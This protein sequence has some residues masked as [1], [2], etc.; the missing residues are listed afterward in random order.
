MRIKMFSCS[1]CNDETKIKFL[2]LEEEINA[3]L[4]DHPDIEIIDRKQSLSCSVSEHVDISYY[5]ECL[6][7]IFY[8]YFGK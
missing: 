7:T 8:N 1:V 4:A 6:I 3:W 2:G 5:T